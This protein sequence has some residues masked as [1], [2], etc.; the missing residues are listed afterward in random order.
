MLFTSTSDSHTGQICSE[1]NC[2]KKNL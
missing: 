1:K 2:I